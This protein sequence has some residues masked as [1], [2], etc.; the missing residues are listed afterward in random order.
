MLL[1]LFYHNVEIRTASRLTSFGDGPEIHHGV[2]SNSFRFRLIE[3]SSIHGY[4]Q[5]QESTRAGEWVSFS[6]GGRRC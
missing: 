1:L 2:Q 5:K 6:E 4:Y 3:G